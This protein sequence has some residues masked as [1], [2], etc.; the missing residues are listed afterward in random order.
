VIDELKSLYKKIEEKDTQYD[1]IYSRYLRALA[2][3]ENLEKRTKSEKQ[4]IIKQ[5]NEK[6]LL[7][8]ID[9]ADTFEKAENDFSSNEMTTLDSVVDGFKAIHKQFRTI[10]KNEGIKRIK[11]QGKK[12]DPK[13]HEVVF[14]KSDSNIEDETILEE[15]QSGYLLNSELLRPTKAVIAKKPK[16]KVKNND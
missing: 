1:K 13:F 15:I 16:E 2:D 7:K 6:L 12:F 4:R 9:L 10:L 11:A 14:V 3:Y 5:A 8:L